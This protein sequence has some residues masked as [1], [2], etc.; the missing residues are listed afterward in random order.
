M[1]SGKTWLANQKVTLVQAHDQIVDVST[2]LT[3]TVY[4][5]AAARNAGIP[6]P[7]GGMQVYLTAEARYEDYQ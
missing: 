6:S 7:T 5:N 4:A 2:A 3:A 1:S